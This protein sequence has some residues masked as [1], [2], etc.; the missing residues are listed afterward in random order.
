MCGIV[1][2]IGD[3]PDQQGLDVVQRMSS[4]IIHRGPDDE[5]SWA[6]PGFAFA[7]RRLSI[8]DLQG[9]HQPMWA[10][11]GGNNLAGIVF[12]GEIYNYRALRDRLI[13]AGQSFHTK[14]DTEVVL[15]LYETEGVEGF[16]RLEGMFAFCLLDRR[17]GLVHLVRDRLGIKP[18]YYGAFD[19]RF[20]FASEIKAILAALDERPSLNRVSLSHYLSLRYVPAPET[21][22]KGIRKLEPGHRLT[23]R[24]DNGNYEI[25]RYW[26]V[27][28]HSQPIDPRRDYLREF[29][30]LFCA[31]VEKHL[32]AADVPVGVLLS[33]GLDS[34]AVSAAAIERGHRNFHTFSVGFADGGDFS[35]LDYARYVASHIGS[36]HHEVIVDQQTF[37]DFLPELVAHTD[38]PLADLAAVPLF[39]VAC[40][41]RDEVKVV[42][43]GEGG[44]EILA[45]YDFDRLAASL[46]RL[47]LLDLLPRFP[48]SLL[49]ALLPGERR[50]LLN[51]LNRTRWQGVLRD[52][53]AY[54]AYF[55]SAAEK[56]NLFRTQMP[57]SGADTEALIRSWYD[58]SP[59]GHPLD[60]LQEAYCA[61]WLVEDI[62][63]KA[64]R[65]SMATSLE[66][67]VP[68][69][70]HSLVE[71]AASLPLTW[72]VGDWRR[73]YASKRILRAFAEKRLPR[74]IIDRPKRGFPVPAYG[75]LSNGLGSWAED[76]LLGS[77][78]RILEL[79]D[80][81]SIRPVLEAACRGS[82]QAAH[83]IWVLIILDF[84]LERWR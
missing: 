10:E 40:L 43:S 75:W 25:S 33:G 45:G 24:L 58:L 27:S 28:F 67:R 14:S 23:Y 11:G 46:D 16:S 7:A 79:L 83:K 22:W 13:A 81:D 29:E 17:R 74:R 48:L 15:R 44:D 62:L 19:S 82:N 32:L 5:G 56:A 57:D 4:T 61:S 50:N 54:I 72:K 66:L 42:L 84:W 49:A 78:S 53:P 73:G 39:H 34:S 18:L 26:Q 76:R 52:Q 47:R 6:Q 41:A 8:I 12:N 38:E 55:W 36:K 31:S 1:G 20:Y 60:Q 70:D 35:E 3:F 64:D 59:S 77:E 21:V 51:R 63:M 69:L 2:M 68:F 37:L 80:G 9:G 30:E 65:M 71:W